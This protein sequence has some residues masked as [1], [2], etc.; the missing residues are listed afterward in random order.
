LTCNHFE[1]KRSCVHRNNN[2]KEK[3]MST[4]NP[5]TDQLRVRF[6]RKP[7]DLNE[8][9]NNSDPDHGCYPVALEF[10]KEMTVAEYDE[11]AANLL[12]D[13]PWLKGRGGFINSQTRSVVMVTAPTR[14]T[15][16][17]DPSGSAYGRYVGVAVNKID[18]INLQ[19]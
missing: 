5:T 11:F 19:N 3:I 6:T 10:I 14:T 12:L 4:I 13:R 18:S 16:F 2:P 7:C 17:V 1:V 15:L 9:L 8:V